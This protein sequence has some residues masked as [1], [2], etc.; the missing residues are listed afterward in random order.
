VLPIQFSTSS[1]LNVLPTLICAFFLFC[2]TTG[3]GQQRPIR[4]NHSPDIFLITIDTLRADHVGCY[5]NYAIKTPALDA[6]AKDGIRFANAFTPSPLTNT[7]HT[8]ILT[9][10]YPSSHGVS[11]FAVPLTPEHLTWAT[12]LHKQGYTSAA[13][14]GAVILD[15]KTLAP[16]LDQGF[17]FYDNFPDPA[18]GKS[19]WGTVER[20]GM[21]VITHAE[22]WLDQHSAGPRFAWMHLYDPHDPYEP[23]PPYSQLYAR[24]P[25][26]GEIAYADHALGTFISY[27]RR[28]GWYDNALVIV[29]GDHGEGLGEHKEET[30]GIFLY[31][32][33]LHVPLIFKLPSTKR[34]PA[35]QAAGT[36][37]ST[38]V[39]TIDILP[40]VLDLVQAPAITKID[41]Q[42]LKALFDGRNANR[43]LFA[44]TDYPLHF[45]WAPL[46]AV[47][48]QS[49]KLI[50]APR[51]EL[52]DLRADP[53]ELHNLYEPWNASVQ[54]LRDLMR[55]HRTTSSAPTKRHDIAPVDPNTIAELRALGYLGPEGSTATP[56]PSLLPDPK[57]KIE[58]Q[59]LLHEAMLESE[60]GQ[61]EKARATLRKLLNANPSDQ[62]AL[63]QLGDLELKDRN[64]QPAAI[65]LERARKLK[66]D[67]AAV[68]YH[69]GQAL[70]GTNDLPKAREALETSLRL[71]PGQL[72]ARLLLGEVCLKLANASAA[73]DQ[74]EAALL[75]DPQNSAAQ[76]GLGRALLSQKKFAEAAT[77]LERASRHATPEIF[78]LLSQAYVGI[79]RKDLARQSADRAARLRE[80]ERPPK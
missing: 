74:F 10:L 70:I 3:L 47:R 57:D 6:L 78:E 52:Y 30:H 28:H 19:H 49:S 25:Y 75:I 38:E 65:Y 17:D 58:L 51:P 66:S 67:D 35:G 11:D 33:T 16:G 21:E 5:G 45:G 62:A 23:P 76:I 15:S 63:A 73:E 79:G 56:E 77:Q 53:K 80:K 41:G 72:P 59:N 24:N 55:Q 44:E 27:L 32:S 34:P 64:F 13:F 48:A 14:I 4:R 37:I 9:G 20:R 69:L 22:K 61:S 8:S 12:T 54:N 2:S 31:D 29:V 26:D 43:P 36:A 60:H 71:L 42:S 68:A 46:R 1:L 40:T 7:S 50:E 39:R 18:A